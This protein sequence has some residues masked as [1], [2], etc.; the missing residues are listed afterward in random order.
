MA[1]FNDL[2]QPAAS[3]VWSRLQTAIGSVQREVTGN[4]QLEII[5]IGSFVGGTGAGMLV[6]M[7][8]LARACAT[9]AVQQ[10][11]IVRGFFVLPRAFATVGGE[12][13]SRRMLAR[14]FA[15]WRELN[16][17]MIVSKDF[18]LRRMD[19]HNTYQPF[20]IAVEKRAFDVCY[21]AD[22]ARADNPLT[23]IDPE[24]GVFPIIADAI[25]AVLDK[26][27]GQQYTEWVTSNLTSAF[28]AHPGVP[29][30]SA[31]GTYTEK[32]PLYYILQEFSH[33]FTL[34]VLDALLA[35]V[36]RDDR[37]GGGQRGK[38]RGGRRWPGPAWQ[39][40][41]VRFHGTH[42]PDPQERRHRG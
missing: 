31:I 1:I 6:D 4:S 32:V 41:D 5:I 40:R 3:E 34:D 10:N 30:H 13:E 2:T 7:A 20:R 19:Y 11:H 22:S 14:S 33:S 18:G 25:S 15:A 36:K 17:F 26:T 37:A 12:A 35:P 8:L 27:A 24:L 39:Q 21:L 23:G 29:L 42:D 9:V 28:S 38:K 16:R